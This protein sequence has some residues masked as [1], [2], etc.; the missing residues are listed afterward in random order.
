ML[1]Y[2][3]CNLQ[4]INQKSGKETKGVFHIAKGHLLHGKRAPFEVQK[5]IF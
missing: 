1:F 4:I 5:G 2:Q 3:L